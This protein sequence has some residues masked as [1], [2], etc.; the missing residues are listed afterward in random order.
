MFISK[1]LL[2][3]TQHDATMTSNPEWWKYIWAAA[4]AVLWRTTQWSESESVDRHWNKW[5]A[6]Q[7][8]MLYLFVCLTFVV[9]GTPLLPEQPMQITWWCL[10]TQ[11]WSDHLQ[12]TLRAVCLKDVIWETN[13]IGLQSKQSIASCPGHQNGNQS[14]LWAV[15]L[16]Q[17]SFLSGC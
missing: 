11:I 4:I 5:S 1:H 9:T 15:G 16:E 17:L 6:A 12:M 14:S 8:N 10:D 7:T 2:C 3:R 13:L